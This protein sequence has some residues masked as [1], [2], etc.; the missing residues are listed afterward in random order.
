MPFCFAS[1]VRR[2]LGGAAELTLVEA[3][4]F[5][6]GYLERVLVSFNNFVDWVDPFTIL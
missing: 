6:G 4:L 2:G 3:F 1:F 5:A